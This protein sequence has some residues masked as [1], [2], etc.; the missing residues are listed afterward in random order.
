MKK[1]CT[2]VSLLNIVLLAGLIYWPASN[3]F[4]QY[5]FSKVDNWL[6]TNSPQLG[7]RTI[8]M[9]YKDGKIV[10]NQSV[11]SMNFRQKAVNKIIARRQ[12]QEANLDDYT[13]TSRQAIASCSKWLSAALVMTFV[14][15]GKLQLN[16]TVGKFLPVLSQHGKGNIT[17]SHCLSHLTAI[18]APD[19]KESLQEMRQVNSMDEAIENIAVLPMEGQPGKVFRYSNTGLQIAGAVLEKITGKSFETLFA[20][21]IA[22]PLNM[23]NTDFG[24]GKVALPAG[25][26]FSTPNDYMNFLVMILNKGLF[27]GKRILSESSIAAMQVNRV[28]KE[29]TVAYAPA[30]AGQF[31]YGFG[32][33]VMGNRTSTTGNESI[34]SPGLFGSFPWISNTHHYCAFLMAFYIKSEGRQERYITLNKLVNEALQ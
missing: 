32:E 3:A 19:L 13:T 15:E 31:G 16:D 8:L 25:G 1:N 24:K 5:N 7:G 18:H 27:N 22:R 2:L 11:N 10:Y 33:W 17:I 26:A 9:V 6:T 12:G 21:R 23:Q 4:A 28:T 14:D 29:V 34:T 20:E 30:E